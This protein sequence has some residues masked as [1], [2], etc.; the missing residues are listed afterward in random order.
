LATPPPPA[1]AAQSHRS[2][3]SQF[4]AAPRQLALSVEP[5]LIRVAVPPQAPARSKGL[6]RACLAILEL[7]SDGRPHAWHELQAVGGSRAN[8]RVGE[9]RRA[10]YVVL[11]PLGWRRLDGVRELRREPLG[12][13]ETERY[14]LVAA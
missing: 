11:G 1:V 3:T 10:G 14:R 4:A 13:G 2:R 8:A 7:L 12:P 6:Q 9:L 5:V